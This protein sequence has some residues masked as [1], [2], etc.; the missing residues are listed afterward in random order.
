MPT[1][2]KSA[3]ARITIKA[4]TATEGK[5]DALVAVFGNVD[6]QGDVIDKG[7]FTDTL[8]AYADAGVPIPILWSHDWDDPD[9]HIGQADASKAEE[10]DEG[11][12]L[13]DVELDIGDNA[14][15]AQVFKLLA[16]GRVTQFS[17]AATT[18]D[19]AGAWSLEEGDDGRIVTH[20]RKLDLIEAGPTLKGANP[21]TRLVGV[22]GM[23]P[24]L[25]D[26]STAIDVN[27]AGR[28]LAAKH[29][30]TL[31]SVVE[32]L[33]S[34]ASD[35]ALLLDAVKGDTPEA[36]PQTTDADPAPVTDPAAATGDT[37]KSARDRA[38]S[39]LASLAGR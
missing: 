20:L 38:S 27:K 30:D 34:A 22:K 35:A 11:L 7:A 23:R 15:A 26:G 18:P 6:L 24:T 29:V 28:R 14:R 39:I 1:F 36:D 12:L 19:E 16:K 2:L 25:R 21:E 5:F 32:R 13:R 33:K 10:T 9:S 37:T 3:D 4:D 8:K 31:T 17:F